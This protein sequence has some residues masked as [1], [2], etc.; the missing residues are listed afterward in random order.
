MGLSSTAEAFGLRTSARLAVEITNR[1]AAGSHSSMDP[2]TQSTQAW[3]G[4]ATTLP[5]S[6][7]KNGAIFWTKKW[8]QNFEAA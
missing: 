5:R 2:L 1:G 6:G 4:F 3:K 8:G 7:P